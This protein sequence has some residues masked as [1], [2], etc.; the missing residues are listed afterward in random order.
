MMDWFG[1]DAFIP[2]GFCLSWDPDLMVTIVLS[3]ALIDCCT[4]PSGR[5]SSAAVYRMCWTT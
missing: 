5:S 1:A 3:N 4:G 2:H